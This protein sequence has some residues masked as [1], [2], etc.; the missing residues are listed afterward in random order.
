M[1]ACTA[2]HRNHNIEC[3]QFVTYI[4][5]AVELNVSQM[6]TWKSMQVTA[7]ASFR[8]GRPRNRA[9]TRPSSKTRVA[10]VMAVKISGLWMNILDNVGDNGLKRGLVPS[11]DISACIVP[12]FK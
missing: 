1:F 6:P 2:Y 7:I 8:K 4:V 12:G 9:G 3:N 10:R 5:P 11:L